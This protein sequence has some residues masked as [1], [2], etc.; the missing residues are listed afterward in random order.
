MTDLATKMLQDRALR[1][2][3]KINV[4]TDLAL[5]MQNIE[6]RSLGTRIKDRALGGAQKINAEIEQVE[7]PRVVYLAGG[8]VG[9]LAVWLAR[10]PVFGFIGWLFGKPSSKKGRNDC[11]TADGPEENGQLQYADDKLA[12]QTGLSRKNARRGT[13]AAA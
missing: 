1:D 10:R 4:D 9:L 2:A 11:F 12:S 5:L 3:A 6:N 13:S 7:G 8:V